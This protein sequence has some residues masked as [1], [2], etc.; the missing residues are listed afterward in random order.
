VLLHAFCTWVLPCHETAGYST[1]LFCTL[2]LLY[3]PTRPS[4]TTLCTAPN[5][6]GSQTGFVRLFVLSPFRPSAGGFRP[7]YAALVPTNVAF[8]WNSLP[9][10]TVMRC[11]SSCWTAVFAPVASLPGACCLRTICLSR[12]LCRGLPSFHPLFRV[13]F[14]IANRVRRICSMDG[15]LQHP[16]NAVLVFAVSNW[17]PPL[18]RIR[19]LSSPFM[20]DVASGTCCAAGRVTLAVAYWFRLGIVAQHPC[21]VFVA[22]VAATCSMPSPSRY[23]SS[24]TASLHACHAA[25]RAAPCH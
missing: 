2:C 3:I 24:S 7:L 18:C 19:T 16:P 21:A 17:L 5:S 9:A 6:T 13:S 12:T 1:C 10:Y 23:R 11:R 14:A 22:V 4:Y 20:V 15:I 25:V 8:C